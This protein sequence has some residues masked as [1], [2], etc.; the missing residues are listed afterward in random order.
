MTSADHLT[1]TV[2]DRGFTHLPPLDGAYGGN[3]RVYESSA[4]DGPHVWLRATTLDEGTVHVHLSANIA[5]QLAEQLVYVVE[6]HYQ[7]Y[8]HA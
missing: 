1:P 2:T 3:V 8:S 4:A 6:H 5:L 7:G